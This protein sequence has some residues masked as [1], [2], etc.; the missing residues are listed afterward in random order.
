[1]TRRVPWL[2]VGLV[3]MATFLGVTTAGYL[4]AA[5]TARADAVAVR[6]PGLV[7]ITVDI[8]Y[9]R[10]RMPAL[11]VRP[12]TVVRFVV[13]NRDPIN[14]EFVIGGPRLHAAHEHGREL[15]HPP[16]PGE[17][18]VA[19]GETG[20]TFFRFRRPGTVRYAC[21]LPGHEAFGMTGVVSVD[22]P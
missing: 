18:S 13:Q 6:G 8:R 21:H 3:A 1:M 4:V 10:F 19:P 12:G 5:A 14:H 22:G 11:H 9:S 20:E 7:T 2:R 17:V 15:I 16:V